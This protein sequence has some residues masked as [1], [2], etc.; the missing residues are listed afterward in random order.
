MNGTLGIVG[1][2]GLAE[3]VVEGYRHAGDQREI[4]LSP[5]GA[6]RAADLAKRF[7]CRIMPSNQAVLDAADNVMVATP[8]K[9]VIAC[10]KSLTWRRGQLLVCV[11]I[12]V[13]LAA[14][15][16]A[17]PE[18]DIVRTMPSS[19]A[20]FGASAMPIYPD[21]AAARALLAPLGA[22]HAVPDER[23]FDAGAAFAGYYLWVYG[24]LDEMVRAGEAAGLPRPAAIGLV[25]GL[26]DA[27]CQHALRADP[28]LPVREP[29][30]R[31][32]TPGTMTA[33]G[34]AI[35]ESA[36]ALAPW[37]RAYEGAV[38]R[39]RRAGTVSAQ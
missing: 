39:L 22:V 29:L 3:F 7:R 12:D 32:G 35:L 1:V 10:V 27:A 14:L 31:H 36:D 19:A 38:Q 17:A 20:A 5:R 2:G 24:L 23:A 21:R 8:P 28:A 6:A 37:R 4:L 11:A 33:G 9:E 25:A 30:D 26:T 15:K 13:T 18:A 16:A 34:Y